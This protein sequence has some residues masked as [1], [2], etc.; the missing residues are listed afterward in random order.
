MQILK[1]AVVGVGGLIVAAAGLSPQ[2][3]T[4]N[5]SAWV[6]FLGLEDVPYWLT[7]DSA[8]MYGVIIGL[9]SVALAF[10]SIRGWGKNTTVHLTWPF[11]RRLEKPIL[12]GSGEHWTERKQL[13]ISILANVSAGLDPYHS[14]IDSDPA[15]SRLREL[16]DAILTNELDAT[17]NGEKP[18]VWSTVTLRDFDLYVATNKTHW[19]EIL[20]RWRKRQDANEPKPQPNWKICKAMDYIAAQFG[21]ENEESLDTKY[22]DPTRL[23]TAKARSGDIKVWGKRIFGKD[24]AELSARIIEPSYWNDIEL[25]VWACSPSS[26]RPQT[27]SAS[28]NTTQQFTDLHVNQTQIQ[29]I[30]WRSETKQ[31][32][33]P[34]PLISLSEVIMR[35]AGYSW[36]TKTAIDAIDGDRLEN[37]WQAAWCRIRDLARAG[38]LSISGRKQFSDADPAARY[39]PLEIIDADYWSN[40]TIHPGESAWGIEAPEIVETSALENCP[41]FVA[42]ADLSIDR[43]DAIKHMLDS[44]YRRGIQLRDEFGWRMREWNQRWASNVQSFFDQELPGSALRF[45][46]AT[47]EIPLAN[48]QV[49]AVM[50]NQ[51]FKVFRELMESA[52]S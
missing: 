23:L 27:Q 12:E 19:N 8:D 43:K 49:E 39:G 24:N 14:P 18:N 21:N 41:G 45:S 40:A 31:D 4:S 7:T 10:A 22:L 30:R 11:L 44:F 9:T 5:L 3:A 38:H 32:Y 34:S 26:R 36:K 20:Q 52:E 16:K 15:L 29:S 46:R 37:T 6:E 33:Q 35:I 25:S 28:H 2:D 51:R 42:Y 47:D 1:W 50:M 13:E 48:R 17:I